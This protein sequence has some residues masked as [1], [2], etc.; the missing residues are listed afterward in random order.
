MI[1]EVAKKLTPS[2]PSVMIDGVP[3]RQC[4]EG[5]KQ[6]RNGS[7]ECGEIK[8][9]DA[10]HWPVNNAY[11]DGFSLVCLVCTDKQHARYAERVATALAPIRI[12][13]DVPI[14]GD[15]VCR[16]VALAVDGVEAPHLIVV[17]ACRFWGLDST[18]QL[19]RI[20]EDAN[21]LAGL[22]PCKLQGITSAKPAYAL[23]YDLVPL[24]LASIETAKMRNKPRA[25]QLAA[26]QRV[27][28]QVLADY[29]FGTKTAPPPPAQQLA[30]EGT[31]ASRPD[32]AVLGYLELNL[33][34][35]VE[36]AVERAAERWMERRVLPIIKG[37]RSYEVEVP[38]PERIVKGEVYFDT[39]NSRIVAVAHQ[40]GEAGDWA[41]VHNL[42]E[43]LNQGYIPLIMGMTTRGEKK[44]AKEHPGKN[45]IGK[46]H[47][48]RP[49][50]TT[51]NAGSLEDTLQSRRPGFGKAIPVKGT[52][53]LFIVHPS[54]L[55]LIRG[56]PDYIKAEDAKW[57]L[58]GW[59]WT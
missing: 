42:I 44:R 22:I 27:C 31:L 14:G 34:P 13:N 38:G 55:T 12:Y 46:S 53:D 48:V 30:V 18:A 43:L 8:P 5:R 4:G 28:G 23:R 15:G 25:E 36:G 6:R 52:D 9:V 35:T 11:S 3:H 51:D 16:G 57:H 50:I 21:L 24:W 26:Y 39:L 33:A 59:E 1:E 20:K 32:S 49:A 41:N 2:P 40:E 29:F 17:E 37:L 19:Q 54:V 45:R 7:I 58:S 10:E 56:L 47:P